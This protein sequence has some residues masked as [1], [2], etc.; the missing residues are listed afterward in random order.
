MSTASHAGMQGDPTNVAAH[1]LHDHHA[2]MGLRGGVETVNGIGGHRN[3][4]IKTK[5]E[6]SAVDVI[7]NGLGHPDNGDAIIRQ[8][9]CTLEGS[10]TTDRDEGVNAGILEV[11]LNLVNS[12]LELI[13][14]QAP[15]T[16]DGSTAQEDAVNV[17][18]VI[19]LDASVGQQALPTIL[20][21]NNGGAEFIGGGSDDSPDD[22]I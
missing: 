14:V 9:L 2:V 19:E 20:I 7:V 10:L 21:A 18:I 11:L 8:P 22:G 6:I 5:G 3:S 17:F 12:S 15:G 13:R 4:R 1:D 16:Q